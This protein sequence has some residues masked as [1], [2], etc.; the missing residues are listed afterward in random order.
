MEG[1]VQ[2]GTVQ[3]SNKTVA[4]KLLSLFFKPHIIDCHLGLRLEVPDTTSAALQFLED[5]IITSFGS[6]LGVS[7]RP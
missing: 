7:F 5:H 3:D 4:G 2:E 6:L 1:V